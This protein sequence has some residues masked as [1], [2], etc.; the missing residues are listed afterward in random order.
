M[1]NYILLGNFTDQGSRTIKDTTKRAD[2]VAELGK[3]FGVNMKD[4]YWTTGQYDLVTFCEAKDEA[5]AMA[6]G[7][8]V[9]SAGNVRVETLRAFSKDDMNG[10][11]AKLS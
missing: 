5:S 10:I 4:I 6:F 8:A 9:M 3:K 2:M 11:L 7:M 1:L